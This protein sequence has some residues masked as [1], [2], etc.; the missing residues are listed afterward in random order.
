MRDL[1][2][3][4]RLALAGAFVHDLDAPLAAA[5]RLALARFQHH[6]QLRRVV[7][8]FH[9]QLR[10]AA[11]HVDGD[12]GVAVRLLGP[13]AGHEPVRFAHRERAQVDAPA[14]ELDPHQAG[15]AGVD[16]VDQRFAQMERRGGPLARGCERDVRHVIADSVDGEPPGLLVP[17]EAAR[18]VLGRDFQDEFHGHEDEAVFVANGRAHHL[19]VAVHHHHARIDGQHKA[20]PPHAQNDLAARRVPELCGPEQTRDVAGAHEPR[21]VVG[22]MEDGDAFGRAA[23][24]VDHLGGGVRREDGRRRHDQRGGDEKNAKA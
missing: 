9:A 12:V 22:H 20:R 24:V 1:L 17:F 18:R 5:G 4:E 2:D 13:N 8:A 11:R 16:V 14:V 21:V 19:R 3:L 7:I 23:V 6:G 10:H 15:R